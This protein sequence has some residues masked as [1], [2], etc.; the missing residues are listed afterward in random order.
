M[1]IPILTGALAIYVGIVAVII[2]LQRRSAAATLAWLLVL[3][4]LPLIGLAIYR[5]IGPLRLERKKFKRS[6]N[7]RVVSDALAALAKLDDET[8]EH[9]QLARVSI[10][11]GEA[12]PLR[13]N[14]VEIFLDGASAYAAML[15]AVAAARHH[16]HLE[17]YIW[18]PDQI[19]TQLR[20]ALVE[21]ARAGVQVRMIVDGTGSS[22]L[23]RKFMAPLLAAGVEVA[24]FNPVGF[25]HR[26]DFRTHRKIVVCDG[27]VGFTGGMNITDPQSALLSKDY[28][29][30]THVLITGIAVW[31]LQRLFIED[32]YFASETACPID[33][34]MFP[35]EETP[36]EHLAQ[37]IGSGPD[38]DAF[39][40]HKVIFTAVNQCTTR[41]WLTTPYFVPDE[42]LLTAIVTAA[43]RDV[44]VRLIVPKKGDS[45]VVDLAARS[46]FPELLAAGVRVY[47]YETRFIHAKTLVCDDDVAIIGTANLDNRSFRLNFEVAA[48]L[49]GDAPNTKLADAF[50]EDLGASREITRDEFERQTFRRRLGQAGARLIS[51]LL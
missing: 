4:F 21:R 15:A 30:D 9:R 31:P 46:Y 14:K 10:K 5:V 47:E 51:P 11:L 27:N 41:C 32:W 1:W 49:V 20:D 36:G 24:R 40:I 25:F 18:A 3:A 6:A 17:Y 22:K 42:A 8:L 26:P 29:R 37:I 45:R 35:A 2:I 28:W 16:I 33:A 44:D 39:A 19:G 23:R 13:A 43:L 12:S 7:K 34:Q 38:S 50:T 48:V